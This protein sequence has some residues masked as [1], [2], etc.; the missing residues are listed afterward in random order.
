MFSGTY[1]DGVQLSKDLGVIFVGFP[2]PTENPWVN[3]DIRNLIEDGR[4]FNWVKITG[5]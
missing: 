5:L 2:S 4:C 1:L 3:R